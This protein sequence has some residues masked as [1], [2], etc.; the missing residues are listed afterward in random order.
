[1]SFLDEPIEMM[2]EWFKALSDPTRLR[3]LHA[4]LAGERSVGEIAGEA[5]ASASAVSH[6]AWRIC[7]P[8]ALSKIGVTGAVFIMRWTTTMSARSLNKRWN[9]PSTSKRRLNVSLR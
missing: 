9:M 5:G 1:M 6:Q 8:S 4:L 3:I 7:A 2:A